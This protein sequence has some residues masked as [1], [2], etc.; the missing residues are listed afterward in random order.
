MT[1]H[2]YLSDEKTRRRDDSPPRLRV[3]L[4]WVYYHRFVPPL[5]LLLVRLP[6]VDAVGVGVV[7]AV[8]FLVAARYRY[9]YY[10]YLQRR[11]GWYYYYNQY[12][13][14][15]RMPRIGMLV[16]DSLC[17]HSLTLHTSPAKAET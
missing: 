13:W 11:H 17:P 3:P 5:L 10:C 12:L 2:C 4:V 16:D 14:R 1:I 9:Y 8:V 15:R 7:V 6:L